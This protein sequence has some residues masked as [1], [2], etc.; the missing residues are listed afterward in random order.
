MSL[1]LAAIDSY[2]NT[3]GIALDLEEFSYQASFHPDYPSLLAFSDAF[4]F[5]NISHHTLRI[6]LQDFEVLPKNFLALARI[7]GQDQIL[8]V[9]KTLSDCLKASMASHKPARVLNARV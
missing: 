9:K 4:S 8:H 5:F 6:G 1:T 2:T 3:E 7:G